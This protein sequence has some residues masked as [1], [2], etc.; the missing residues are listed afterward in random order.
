MDKQLKLTA[1]YEIFKEFLI[2]SYAKW[3]LWEMLWN[4]MF[5]LGKSVESYADFY[6]YFLF[7]M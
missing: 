6:M 5:L 4:G 7:R 2:E 3:E 1:L